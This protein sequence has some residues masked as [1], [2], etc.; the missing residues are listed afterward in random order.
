MGPMKRSGFVNKG[1]DLNDLVALLARLSLI[2]LAILALVAAMDYG[3]VIVAPVALGVVIGLMVAP[4]ALA[5]ERLGLSSW[6]SSGVVV[7]LLLLIIMAAIIG[8]SVPISGWVQKA[9]EI[10]QSL[11]LRISDWKAALS[12][13][14]EF[15]ERLGQAAGEVSHLKVTVDEGTGVETVAILAPAY[16]AQVLLFLATLYFFVATRDNFRATVL[17]LCVGRSLRWRTARIF[18]DAEQLMSRYLFSITIINVGLGLAVGLAL[19]LIGM[20]SPLLWGMLASVLNYVV[21]VGPALMT[22][23]LLAISLATYDDSIA[24]LIPPGVYLTLNLIESQLVTPRLLGSSMT[25]NPFLIFLSLTFWL[26]LWGPVGGFIAVPSLLI[27]SAVIRNILPVLPT[28]LAEGSLN[29]RLA[30]WI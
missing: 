30:R 27:L 18:R 12:S 4:A 3:E 2:V 11:Q 8:F 17:T 9:P 23:L 29:K 20:P 25:I 16:L 14:S 22:A 13:L 28:P 26:W 6:L 19:W 5:L 21:Y 7:L 10:W 1:I 24:I 15:R